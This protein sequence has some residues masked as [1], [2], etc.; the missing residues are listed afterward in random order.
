MY[1][2]LLL[3]FYLYIHIRDTHEP[4]PNI[5]FFSIKYTPTQNPY[6]ATYKK[7][8]NACVC[9][10]PHFII[11]NCCC[12]LDF[13]YHLIISYV[14]ITHIKKNIKW[15]CI[16]EREKKGG[17]KNIFYI[18]HVCKCKCCFPSY[19]RCFFFSC[20]AYIQG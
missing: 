11:W 19:F 17:S 10:L 5:S 6:N 12:F 13:L 16:N 8:S 7:V 18:I 2:L 1:V 4:T 3:L 14:H 15:K 9:L 20:A